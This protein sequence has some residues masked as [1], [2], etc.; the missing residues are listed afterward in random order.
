MT[1]SEA[2][3]GLTGSEHLAGNIM[4]KII[5]SPKAAALLK[6]GPFGDLLDRAEHIHARRQ[7][8]DG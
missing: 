5:T 2:F 3:A 8:E 1:A 7:K 6:R 4:G